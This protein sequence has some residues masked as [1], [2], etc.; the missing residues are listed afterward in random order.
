MGDG[1]TGALA[2][3]G[4]GGGAPHAGI[5]AGDSV[6]CGQPAFLRRDSW[7]RHGRAVATC[8]CPGRDNPGAAGERGPWDIGSPDWE[9]NER[10]AGKIA[11]IAP[12]QRCREIVT[13]GHVAQQR[14]SQQLVGGKNGSA[15]PNVGVLLISQRHRP[16]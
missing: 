12:G 8:G 6:S 10:P 15:N 5:T 3:K 11:E 2:G 16:Q 13:H 7:F 14:Q 1:G 4:D 9:E